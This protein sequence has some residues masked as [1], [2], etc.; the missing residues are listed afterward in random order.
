MGRTPTLVVFSCTIILAL[1]GR[2][3]SQQPDFESLLASAQQAQTRGDFE[4]AAGFYR[5]AVAIHPEIAELNA[6]LGL[7]CYQIGKDEQAIGAFRQANRLNPELFVSNLFL[8]RE[9][10]KLKRFSEAIPYLK[11]AALSKPDDINVQLG[12]AQAYSGA[13]KRRL[14]ITSYLHAAQIDP[15]DAN[16]LY[17]L[18]VSYLEQVEADA[19]ILVARHKDSSYF[20]VLVADNFSEQHAFIQA[21]EAYQQ[22][23]LSPRVPPGTRANYGFVLLH[24]H[25]LT[26][27]E[28]AFKAELTS[29][30][31][32]LIAKS[33][34]ARLQLE[35]GA[36]EEA[37]KRIREIWTADAGFLRANAIFFEAGLPQPKRAELQHVLE[38]RQESGDD[39]AELISLLQFGVP[40]TVDTAFA[41]TNPGDSGQGKALNPAEL[42][43]KGEYRE[44]SDL[45]S[46]RLE[47]L[48][49]P[50][51]R[52]LVFCAYST[53][54][55]QR[56]FNAA[57]QMVAAPEA[58]AEGLYFE[59][60]SAQKLA[61]AALARASEMDSSS[62]KLHILLGDINRHRKFFSEAEQEYRK[63]LTLQPEDTGARFGLSLALLADDQIDE[64][65]RVAQTVLTNSPDDPEFNAVM[66]EI[67]CARNDFA[68]AEP[69]LTKSLNTKPEYVPHVHALLGKVYARTGHT[70]QAITEFKL[71]LAD[72]KDG[73]VHYQIGR[74]YLKIGDRDSA[75]Q[76]FDI[77]Q[78]LRSEGL[79][80]ATVAMQQGED[81]SESQ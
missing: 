79:N 21:A 41:A 40:V 63:A 73:T 35:Q 25:D 33:G 65:F 64:A 24:R 10:V 58:E 66:G 22:A 78:R 53:G 37:S 8:G 2:I 27:A 80:R 23:L 11:R 5:Q 81:Q 36:I 72:D 38:E 9:Y 47:T 34:L 39:S 17:H 19:R 69:Y 26:G 68:G 70:Q 75:K 7:M 4:S 74:L 55:Y 42:Y 6:N 61:T 45:L 46:P 59:T 49:I 67:L 77:S 30:P 20:Q 14:A 51:L 50:E 62:P 48:S 3:S 56:A 15:R 16:I 28:R 60:K 29:S 31:G 71:A 13:G 44:C 54:E 18:G 12:L 57:A 76:A 43:A 1:S 52:M 32:S